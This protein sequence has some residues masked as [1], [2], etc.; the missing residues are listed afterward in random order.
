MKKLALSLVVGAALALTPLSS[1]ALTAMSADNM[2]D[3]T[4]QAGV[5]IA[6]D[7]ITLYQTVGETM[8]IDTDGMDDGNAAAIVIS[9]K[10]AL[11]TIRAIADDTN[12]G[13]FLKDAMGG[14]S[15][16]KEILEGN[17]AGTTV[18]NRTVAMGS[19]IEIAALSIDVSSACEISTTL[20][21]GVD[22]A[23]V[24]IGLPTIEICKTG[25]TQT[26][27]VYASNADGDKLGGNDFIQ[28][29]KEDSVLAVLG[30]TLE[31][32]PH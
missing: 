14:A 5:S 17:V 13:G 21:G 11:V 10:E 29:T 27:G 16:Y 19:H 28:I 15:G 22:V 8:Y 12:R 23:G 18:G 31:I 20:N 30:G 1:F 9:D 24:I 2:K 26:I 3:A 32:A 7:D 4:G 25:D 6:L